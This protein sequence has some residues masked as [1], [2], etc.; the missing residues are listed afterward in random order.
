MTTK[1]LR[2][3]LQNAFEDIP[4]PEEDCTLRT[5]QKV[6]HFVQ[7]SQAV[8]EQAEM[9]KALKAAYQKPR[10][11]EKTAVRNLV[12]QAV[13]EST[14]P[15]LRVPFQ[16]RFTPLYR[17]PAFV[18]AFMLIFASVTLLRPLTSYG[19]FD[20]FP[21][22][23][24]SF[25]QC[26]GEVVVNG[27]KCASGE[28]LT[29]S[30]GDVIETLGDSLATIHYDDFRIAR[31]DGTS[32]AV[33]EGD[34]KSSLALESGS[35][36]LHSPSDVRNGALKVSTPDVKTRLPEGAAGLSVRGSVFEV[37]TTTAAV[38]LQLNA[39]DGLT[40]VFTVA[41][42][43]KFLLRRSKRETRV[44]EVELQQRSEWVQLNQQLDAE[45]L[46]VV[47]E[48]TLARTSLGAGNLPGS[49]QDFLAK[50]NRSTRVLLT[51]DEQRRL[52]EQLAELDE[53]FSEV[54][55]L[56]DKG[57]QTTA[58]L[59]LKAYQAKFLSLVDNYSDKI[60]LGI[61]TND[62]DVL[63][64][65]LD[66]HSELV[67]PFQVDDEQYFIKDSLQRLAA[68]VEAH[69][70][71]Q[72][73]QQRLRSV[74]RSRLLE[75]HR[76]AL[77]SNIPSAKK[78]LRDIAVL[79]EETSAGSILTQGEHMTILEDLGRINPE[80]LEVVKDIRRIKVDLL[81]AQSPKTL[82][83]GIV[84]RVITGTAYIEPE[85]ETLTPEQKK[86]TKIVGQAVEG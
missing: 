35:V 44:R 37:I 58:E 62:E 57:D 61:E 34:G 19:P 12:M 14:R 66:K 29:L 48:R 5:R 70:A 63:W 42:D 52:Y 13:E 33:F 65:L 53:L 25:L 4:S 36:W 26:E 2:A 59:T 73:H 83:N 82:P 50:L 32:K 86:T 43:K 46:E 41:P 7:E 60:R 47:K 22:S 21:E 81:K 56:H 72:S 49:I 85:N 18:T 30:P 64:D 3:H 78:Q 38:E 10:S 67:S 39:G 74:F 15:T 28:Q 24:A 17:K 27:E 11:A 77:D 80:L 54:L 69:Y 8:V 23:L 84:G 79:I 31:L 1:E 45:H 76:T 9:V 51:W 71:T 75:A 6:M 20:L 55:V 16:I 40:E 68:R